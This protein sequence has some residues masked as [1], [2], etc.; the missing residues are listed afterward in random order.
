MDD[1]STPLDASLA[2]RRS[3]SRETFENSVG[4]SFEPPG[5]TGLNSFSTLGKQ[6]AADVAGPELCRVICAPEAE[7]FR[8]TPRLGYFDLH[9]ER[10]PPSIST[11]DDDSSAGR[12]AT[13][14]MK[15][16]FPSLAIL[17]PYDPSPRPP[18]LPV[19]PLSPLSTYRNSMTRR[20]SATLI[21]KPRS[22][23]D[24]VILSH[25]FHPQRRREHAL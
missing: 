10:R 8:S 16:P 12:I 3:S 4:L 1:A 20:T 24:S 25:A 15:S 18:D 21:A 14:S 17:T 23:A 19:F 2:V 6:S 5:S 22:K 11:N 13:T 9:P 7:N